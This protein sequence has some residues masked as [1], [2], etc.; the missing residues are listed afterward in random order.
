MRCSIFEEDEEM[1][2]WKSTIAKEEKPY[3][4]AI[5]SSP[6]HSLMPIPKLFC[7]FCWHK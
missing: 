6:E 2:G 7:S 3:E 5:F 4:Q 1:L